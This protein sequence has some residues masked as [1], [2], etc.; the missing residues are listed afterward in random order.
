[1]PDPERRSTASGISGRISERLVCFPRVDMKFTVAAASGNAFA[2]IWARDLP[3]HLNAS[4]LARQICSQA[5]G[6]QETGRCLDGLFI[7]GD[8]VPGAPW[9][10]DHF[11]PNGERTFCSNGTRA[12][13]A[14]IPSEWTGCIQA[15]VSGQQVL[16]RVEK[17]PN[18]RQ[19]GLQMPEGPGY[20][21]QEIPEL[22]DRPHVLGFTG[23]P[24][25]IIQVPSVDDVDLASF[26]PPLRHHPKLSQG[27]N[28]SIVEITDESTARIRTWERGVEGETLC[29]GQGCAVAGAWLARCGGPKKWCFQPMGEDPV[30]VEVAC[31]QDSEWKNLWLSGPIRHLGESFVG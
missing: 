19:V 30:W 22:L 12:A 4:A 29:C 9:V 28:V 1:M 31:V 16:L 6:V 20:G 14:L 26:A 15:C 25:L 21:F 10:M 8:F 11:E 27:A 24:H 23:T 17:N 5:P 3:N 13:V 2:Y 18:L 7:V